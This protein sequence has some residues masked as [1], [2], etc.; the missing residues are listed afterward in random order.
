[1]ALDLTPVYALRERLNA[2]AMAGTALL[3]EDF[4][5]RRA[6]EAFA[7]LEAASPVFAK[8][9]RS[10]R[11]LLSADCPD[12]AGGLLEAMNLLEAVLCTQAAVGLPGPVQPI[13]APADP[14]P[15][16]QIPYSVLHPLLESLHSGRAKPVSEQRYEHPEWF[17]D[18]RVRMAL[19]GALDADRS[20]LAD[21]VQRW[22]SSESDSL[23]PLLKAGF[24]PAEPKTMSRRVQVIEAIAG[25]AENEFYRTSLETAAGTT[26]QALIF[27]LRHH[28]QNTELLLTL[29]RTERGNAKKI[30]RCALACMDAPE[31]WQFWEKQLEKKPEEIGQLEWATAPAAGR[32]VAKQLLPLLQTMSRPMR[33][34]ERDAVFVME[35]L[36]DALTGKCGEEI[37]QLY[38]YA[39]EFAQRI[40]TERFLR[41]YLHGISV[42]GGETGVTLFTRILPRQLCVSLVANPAPDLL[43]LA[44]EL[45]QTYGDGWLGPY[46]TAGLLTLPAEQAY[47][48]LETALC[49]GKAKDLASQISMALTALQWSRTRARWEL[50]LGTRDPVR[51]TV[52]IDRSRPLAQ[53][54]DPR[55][56]PR[57]CGLDEP[58][59]DY[60]LIGFIR[61]G[62]TQTN[63][64]L[65]QTIYRHALE[66]DEP[67]K[68]PVC[69]DALRQCGWPHCKGLAVR[70]FMRRGY[71][72]LDEVREM[73]YR[74][75]G[76]KAAVAQE[77]DKLYALS[78]T[79][80]VR[81]MGCKKEDFY[82]LAAEWHH[83]AAEEKNAQ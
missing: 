24:D 44:Q 32:L 56:V 57:L 62:D 54:P 48:R 70:Y 1:M 59:L 22:L 66:V 50:R 58:R 65:G 40:R 21:L 73:L 45:Y 26:R 38:R 14:A 51:D 20:Q 10:V 82:A 13:A 29:A 6:L 5:L 71:L 37:C 23:L 39:A 69:I 46:L 72:D 52:F 41:D 4:R 63:T 35:P 67:Y 33:V 81:L 36:I 12:P 9:G 43:A 3:A 42:M 80:T 19:V 27:A 77:A 76:S 79:R 34:A 74:L 15:P 17:R 31:V 7:P 2:A 55:W 16:V 18:H 78:I 75:P 47:L 28:P 8:I 25:A 61:P 60:A 64:L 49:A 68:M 11:T 30:A 53:P 83:K